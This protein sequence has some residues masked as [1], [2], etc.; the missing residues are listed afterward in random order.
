MVSSL[1]SAL[2][3]AGVSRIEQRLRGFLESGALD[4]SAFPLA[5]LPGEVFELT[6]LRELNL[7]QSRIE[8]LPDAIG[9]L[10]DLELLDMWNTPVRRISGAIGRL[11]SLRGLSLGPACRAIPAEI[12]ELVELRRLA[13]GDN[14]LRT[15]PGWVFRLAR[16]ED[17]QLWENGLTELPDAWD[18]LPELRELNLADNRL[19]RLPGSL[20]GLR[21]L[22]RLDLTGND[23]A[24]LPAVLSG[25][26][27]LRVAKLGGN[28][29]TRLP[30]VVAEWSELRVLDLNAD[31]GLDVVVDKPTE[32]VYVR[33][34]GGPAPDDAEP[35]PLAGLPRRL[36]GLPHLRSLILYGN[37]LLQIPEE[38]MGS[39]PVDQSTRWDR[40]VDEVLTYYFRSLDNSRPLNEAKL[41]LVGWGGVGKT[42]LVRRLVFDQFSDGEPR[43]EGIEVTNWSVT[44]PDGN[45]ARLNVWDFGGQEIMHATHQFFLTSRSVY[46]VVLT[47]RTGSAD[48][49]AEYWLRMVASF[50]PGSPIII[51]LNQVDKDPIELDETGLRQR[52]PEIRAFLRTDCA[53]GPHGRGIADLRAEILRQTSGLPDL[54]VS[55]PASWFSIKDRLAVMKENY[56]TFEAYRRICADLGEEDPQAQ[57][58]LANYLHSLGIALNYREDPRLRD[59]HVLNPRWVTEGIYTILN[60]RLV[61]ANDGEVETGQLAEIL[62]PQRYPAERHAFLLD[63]MRKFDLC[64]AF[65]E[66]RHKY[67]IADL[68]PKQQPEESGRYETGL[69]FEYRYPVLPEGL[70][71]RF[72]VRSHVM[73]SRLRWRG[74]CVLRWEDNLALV[75]ADAAD[76]RVRIWVS[77]PPEGRRRLLAVVRSDLDHIHRSY[78]FRV[79]AWVPTTGNANLAVRYE[80]LV[81]AERKK[82]AELTKFVDNDFVT[83]DVARELNGVDTGSAADRDRVAARLGLSAAR[84]SASAPSVPQRSCRIFISYSHK[85]ETFKD[86][87]VGHLKVLQ[88]IGLVE[89]WHDRRI[90]PGGDWAGE[91]DDALIEADITLFLISSDFLS[92]R[93]CNEVEVR[94]A[95][96]RHERGEVA[97]VPVIIRDV[98]W[99]SSR[100]AGLQAVPTDG[101]AVDLWPHRDTAWRIVSE[102]VERLARERMGKT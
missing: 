8:T 65:P 7:N 28:R 70:L 46:V 73:S 26:S 43:T 57:D 95:F 13:I 17:L 22:R 56:L 42:S 30:D 80:E 72:I 5:D 68:L 48:P 35:S 34:E 61:S 60:S 44:L 4:L 98:N 64:F 102:H 32:E 21:H 12:G 38:V 37:P 85:D 2:S 59:T 71:P 11:A 101:K 55:F 1:R 92:S 90:D 40:P 10:A 63:L 96:D 27:A 49:D 62:D 9:G 91:I 89:V 29:F 45:A 51:A 18:R 88:Q 99:R 54:R 25:L 93:Y 20:G 3:R 41:V 76:R 74:G 77:G 78:R 52:F 100:F 86:E 69:R 94:T 81:A 36:A 53:T 19:T 87:L 82:I 15:V 33:R 39:L 67:L 79:E 83:L 23:L 58:Q 24:D 14:S 16:L 97:I 6:G 84:G 50:A 66:E 31:D 75:R 47:G